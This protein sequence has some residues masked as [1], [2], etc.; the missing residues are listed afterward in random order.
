MIHMSDGTDSSPL[1]LSVWKFSNARIKINET[2]KGSDTEGQTEAASLKKQKTPK[3]NDLCCFLLKV[4][5]NILIVTFEKC[6][7]L[8]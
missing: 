5:E 3:K 4:L 8:P 6:L 2:L 7:N 1:K